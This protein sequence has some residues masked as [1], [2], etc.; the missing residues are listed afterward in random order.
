MTPSQFLEKRRK[1]L[2]YSFEPLLPQHKWVANNCIIK[3]EGSEE[4]GNPISYVKDIYVMI[5]N[6]ISHF[7]NVPDCDLLINRKDFQ[8][9][10]SNH[11]K[12]AHTY[13]Y[14]NNVNINNSLLPNKYWIVCSQNSTNQ[15]KDV[16]IPNADEWKDIHKKMNVIDWKNKENSVIFRGSSTGCGLDEKS[17]P[18]LRLSQIGYML[19]DPFYNIGLSKFVKKIRVNEYSYSYINTRKYEHLLKEFITPED[20]MKA[21]YTLNIEG[22]AAAYRLAGLFN[23][24]SVVV[25][26]ESKYYNWFEPLLKDGK[27]YVV[28]KKD[29]YM[30]EKDDIEVSKKKV[31]DFFKSLQEKNGDMKKIASNGTKFFENYLNEKSIY[32]YYFSVMK[33]VNSFTKK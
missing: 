25:Q 33:K 23:M 1:D 9:L 5:Q 8:Y 3:I 20:Q 4:E 15:N 32:E 6:T 28:L 22:N 24:N 11:S 21:K 29:V 16:P 19:S 10:H 30:N 17:N 26:A 18:R 31:D 2:K 13:I 27:D 7:K 14:P 12:F